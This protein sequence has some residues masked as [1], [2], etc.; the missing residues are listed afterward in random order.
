MLREE[1][2]FM[3]FSAC[4]TVSLPQVVLPIG[5]HF[6]L[7]LQRLMKLWT[8]VMLSD[9]GGSA[10]QDPTPCHPVP[11]GNQASEREQGR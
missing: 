1:A 2:I 6:S 3:S 4:S 5:A 9:T 7:C 11:S 10:H 8:E